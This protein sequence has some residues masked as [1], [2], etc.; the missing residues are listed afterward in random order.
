M[1]KARRN[2]DAIQILAFKKG[3]GDRKICRQQ[4]WKEKESSGT[5]RMMWLVQVQKEDGW[6][7]RGGNWATFESVFSN[8][9]GF[10]FFF[11]IVSARGRLAEFRAVFTAPGLLVAEEVSLLD[12]MSAGLV[13]RGEKIWPWAK[14]KEWS[15]DSWCLY[16]IPTQV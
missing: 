4:M 3:G 14:A 5:R 7:Q 10:S 11:F 16:L 15:K 8:G 12:H 1:I 2:G 9:C 13:L 6:R